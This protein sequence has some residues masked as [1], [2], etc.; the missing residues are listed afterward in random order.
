M[1]FKR[2][3]RRFL[4]YI[5]KSK[6]FLTVLNPFKVEED[7]KEVRRYLG[8]LVC[9]ANIGLRVYMQELLPEDHNN[10]AELAIINYAELLLKNDDQDQALSLKEAD[11]YRKQ[12]ALDILLIGGPPINLTDCEFCYQCGRGVV[13]SSVKLT[14]SK[15]DNWTC[16]EKK[17]CRRWYHLDC[18][19]MKKKPKKGV[20]WFCPMCRN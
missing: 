5:N 1:A 19:K 3:M 11:K 16:C 6:Q 4:K 18:L 17:D 14:N 12:I 20:D 10:D 2:C 9:I 7:N 13:E 8:S 15:K